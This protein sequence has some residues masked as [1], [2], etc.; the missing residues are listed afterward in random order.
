MLVRRNIFVQ[1]LLPVD[2]FTLKLEFNKHSKL[3]LL[4]FYGAKQFDRKHLSPQKIYFD[5]SKFYCLKIDIQKNTTK[6]TSTLHTISLPQM[7][8]E[9]TFFEGHQFSSAHTLKL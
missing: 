5:Y 1:T 9:I 6:H 7:K 8:E 4:V 3:L 2:F